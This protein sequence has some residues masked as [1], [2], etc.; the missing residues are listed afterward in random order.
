MSP[1]PTALFPMDG[2]DTLGDCTIAALESIR[3]S[4]VLCRLCLSGLGRIIVG[5]TR[6]VENT[7]AYFL[8]A[9]KTQVYR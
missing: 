8:L 5:E 4:G 2:N 6:S 9:M 1:D 3:M 7:R